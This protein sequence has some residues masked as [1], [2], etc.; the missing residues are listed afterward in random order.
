MDAIDVPKSWTDAFRPSKPLSIRQR[1][2]IVA[3]KLESLQTFSIRFK[4]ISAFPFVFYLTV[5]QLYRYVPNESRQYIDQTSLPYLDDL[6]TFGNGQILQRFPRNV[7]EGDE[8]YEGLVTALDLLMSL[9]YF[10]HFGMFVCFALFLL[11]WYWKRRDADGQ[12]VPQPWLYL[13]CLGITTLLS[14]VVQIVWPTAPP[15]YSQVYGDQL[16]TYDVR[17]DPAGLA[18]TDTLINWPLFYGIY[19]EA[20]LVF[21]SFPSLH[22]AWPIVIAYNVP[23][24]PIAQGVAWFYVFWVWWAAMYL[25]HHYLFDLIGSAFFASVGIF[26]G[27]TTMRWR[28][29]GDGALCQPELRK[30]RLPCSKFDLE[31]QTSPL[32]SDGRSMDGGHECHTCVSVDTGRLSSL[33]M[34]AVTARPSDGPAMIALRRLSLPDKNFDLQANAVSSA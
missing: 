8:S 9:V 3:R 5:F 28:L 19:S 14:A 12:P 27:V 18:N 2:S 29:A 30:T 31:L 22:G 32:M 16:A 11:V 26:I 17:G 1:C 6:L 13:W 33:E 21:A 20:P 7:L 10:I 34:D 25:N 24:N 4:V 23:S 15:W